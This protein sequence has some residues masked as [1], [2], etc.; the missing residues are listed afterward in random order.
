M[1]MMITEE[2]LNE[3]CCALNATKRFPMITCQRTTFSGIFVVCSQCVQLYNTLQRF[4]TS[5]HTF[6]QW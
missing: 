4:T 3:S 6:I 5:T 2:G 1:M